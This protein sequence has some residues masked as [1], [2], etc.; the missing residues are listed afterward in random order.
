[1]SSRRSHAPGSLRGSLQVA[2]ERAQRLMPASVACAVDLGQLV[3]G[4]VEPV[5][6]GDVRPPAAR[7]CSRRSAST[8][9][10]GRAASRRAPSA[11]GV[12]PR[13]AAISFSARTSPSVLVGEHVGRA[14]SSPWLAARALRD[15]RPGTGRS[16]SPARAARTRCSRR[17]PRRARRA[18]PCSIQRLSIEYDGWW[19]SSGVPSSRRIAAAS[20]GLLRP[21]RRRCRRRAPCPAARRCRARP[22]S[23]RAAC[24]GSKRCE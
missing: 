14:A 7:R 17:P 4:E 8:S 23:P 12:W 15:R 10:A 18:G 3:V 22:S 13:R 11:P 20:R 16:A 9:P 24:P 21:S 2:L 5:E 6:R 1:M 19:M